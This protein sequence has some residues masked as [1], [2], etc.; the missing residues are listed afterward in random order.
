MTRRPQCPGGDYSAA[1]SADNSISSAVL[2]RHKG[3]FGRLVGSLR[4]AMTANVRGGANSGDQKADPDNP[5][6]LK[7]IIIT[8]AKTAP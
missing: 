6:R 1:G 2:I 7:G 4:A 5:G 8:D 3:R